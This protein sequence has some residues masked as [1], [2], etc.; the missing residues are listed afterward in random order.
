[1]ISMKLK[2]R[3]TYLQDEVTKSV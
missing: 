3:I 2:R 1:M